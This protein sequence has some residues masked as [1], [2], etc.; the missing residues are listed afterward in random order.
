MAMQQPPAAPEQ[1]AA[2]QP[3]EEG[4]DE[5]GSLI[6]NLGT[7]M[8]MLVEIIQASGAPAPLVEKAGALMEGF[9]SLADELAGG[10]APAQGGASQMVAQEMGGAKASPASPA[11]RG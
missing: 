6:S 3:Q 5:I 1:A 9:S 11:M 8:Q 10:Q 2:A 4:G 7:G